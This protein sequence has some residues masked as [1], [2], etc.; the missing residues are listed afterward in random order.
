[1]ILAS[2]ISPSCW[3]LQLHDER[4][5]FRVHGTADPAELISRAAVA[6]DIEPSAD[7]LAG[8]LDLL[9]IGIWRDAISASALS[10][11]HRQQ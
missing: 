4:S 8:Q 3:A 6:K 9:G 7:E 10:P 2:S 1:M 5:I 11:G